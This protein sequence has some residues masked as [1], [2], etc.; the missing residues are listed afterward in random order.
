MEAVA[1]VAHTAIRCRQLLPRPSTGLKMHTTLALLAMLAAVPAAAFVPASPGGV[2]K[3]EPP[4]ALGIKQSS[5]RRSSSTTVMMH[6]GDRDRE[7]PNR[8]TF[9]A[10]VIASPF[11]LADRCVTQQTH[12]LSDGLAELSAQDWRAD[13]SPPLDPYGFHT[14]GSYVNVD[15]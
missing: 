7:S 11:I 10:G 6:G 3:A 2:R 12:F 5:C 13:Y 4:M 9:V 1:G 14:A 8:R 15:I